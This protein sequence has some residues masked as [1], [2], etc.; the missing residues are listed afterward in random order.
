[1]LLPPPRAPT[2]TT[3]PS[4]IATT[5]VL[6]VAPSIAPTAWTVTPV[7]KRPAPREPK[8]GAATNPRPLKTKTIM[9]ALN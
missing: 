3:A 9:A 4:P 5:V 2:L 8:R 7:I 1:V 6:K